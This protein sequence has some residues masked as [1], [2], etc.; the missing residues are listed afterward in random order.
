MRFHV[1]LEGYQ[2]LAAMYI[3]AALDSVVLGDMH[4][5]SSRLWPSRAYVMVKD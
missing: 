4:Q 2:S 3:T 5:N 1:R